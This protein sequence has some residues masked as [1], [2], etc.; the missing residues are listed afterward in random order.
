[1]QYQYQPPT[2]HDHSTL[3][4]LEAKLAEAR[5]LWRGAT[6]ELGRIWDLI[7]AGRINGSKSITEGPARARVRSTLEAV[8]AA[9]AEWLAEWKRVG[10]PIDRMQ[11]Q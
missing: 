7:D 6:T 1:M 9:Y 11:R 4:A 8:D 5:R 10:S 2:P 3:D